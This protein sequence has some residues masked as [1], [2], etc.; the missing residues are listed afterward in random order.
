MIGNLYSDALDRTRLIRPV[1]SLD[2]HN[3]QCKVFVERM[4]K[5]GSVAGRDFVGFAPLPAKLFEQSPNNYR[6]GFILMEAAN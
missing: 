6:Y 1:K 4:R 2:K 5:D 3:L